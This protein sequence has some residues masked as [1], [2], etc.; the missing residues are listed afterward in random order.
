MSLSSPPYHSEISV[1]SIQTVYIL[2]KVHFLKETCGYI[3]T[4]HSSI[5]KYPCE[6]YD[7]QLCR[8]L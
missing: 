7:I 1:H 3:S 2:R 5:S 6:V 8:L 4:R